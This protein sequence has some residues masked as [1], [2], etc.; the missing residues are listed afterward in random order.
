LAANQEL[1]SFAYAVSH[2]LRAP[3]RAMSGFSQALIEDYSD[4][5]DAE[6]RVYLDQIIEASH[7][8]S[9]LIEGILVL[10]RSTRVQLE[11]ELIDLSAM[12]KEIISDLAEIEPE[13]KVKC[14][15]EPELEV[16]GDPKTVEVLMTNLLGNAWKYTSKMPDSMIKVSSAKLDDAA[17]IAIEDNGAGFDQAHANRLFKPF[18]RLHRQDEFPGTGIGLATVQRIVQR[19]GGQI[20]ATAVPGEG[21]RFV[22]SLVPAIADEGSSTTGKGETT[23]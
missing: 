12:V 1:D 4:Q 8:M 23:S 17:A 13:R 9:E 11:R 14:I 20:M 16:Y 19:H 5:L 7:K 2:D 18:Q 10:S 22:F 15:V 6:A 21:A 3:L